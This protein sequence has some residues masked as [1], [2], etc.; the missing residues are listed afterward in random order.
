[1]KAYTHPIGILM[2]LLGVFYAITKDST[3]GS[4]PENRTDEV[5]MCATEQ[6]NV[7]PAALFTPNLNPTTFAPLVRKN[8]YSLSAAEINSIKTGI[9]AM[10]ALPITNKTSWLYQAAIHGTTTLPVQPSWNTCQHGTQFFLSWHRMYLYYFERILRAKSGNPSLTLPYWNYQ[11]NPALHPDYRSSAPGNPLYDGTRNPSINGGGS[12]PAAISA[13][14]NTALSKIPFN[15]FQSGLEGPHGSVHVSIGGNMGA[16]SRAA[17]DPVFWLHHTNVDRLWSQWIRMC[18]G[19]QN[20]TD[21][22]W[23][24][25]TYTFFDENGTAINMTGSQVVNTAASLN[26]VYDF[27]PSLPCNIKWPFLDWVVIRPFKLPRPLILNQNLIKTSFKESVATPDAQKIANV[28]LNLNSQDLPDQ[29]L[30]DLNGVKIDRL[31]EGVIEVYLNL[32][33]NE[34]PTPQ[35]RSFVGVLDLFTAAAHATHT[36]RQQPVRVNISD[37][38]ARMGIKMAADLNKIDLS[39]VVRG[40][41]LRGQD[42]DARSSLSIADMDIVIERPVKK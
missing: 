40:N 13:S 38:A 24:N 25:Q 32:P 26:Y 39:F 22:V 12:L 20:P 27:P 4:N 16:V 15:V 5:V 37:A 29:V 9:A 23:L 30:V 18:G 10:K 17:Q 8:I 19:R 36:R 6:T 33:A 42:V 31:P 3:T 11:T 21:N 28:A 14:I 2:V 7:I 41:N 35:S 34:K 1:M